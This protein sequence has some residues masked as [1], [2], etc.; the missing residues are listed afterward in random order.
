[1]DH[2]RLSALTS[3]KIKVLSREDGPHA[4]GILTTPLAMAALAWGTDDRA[5]RAPP[6][7]HTYRHTPV[8]EL[9]LQMHST[10]TARYVSTFWGYGKLARPLVHS[11]YRL[12]SIVNTAVCTHCTCI[13]YSVSYRGHPAGFRNL[14]RASRRMFGK[15]K[16][17]R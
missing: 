12:Y 6:T 17:T 9:V 4:G 14:R 3:R 16:T 7:P 11:V 10:C 8:C 2:K 5:P 13:L 15:T 1:M